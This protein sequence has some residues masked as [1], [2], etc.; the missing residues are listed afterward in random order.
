L[1]V[2]ISPRYKSWHKEAGWELVLRKPE[3]FVSLR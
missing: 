3:R 2:H 1:S